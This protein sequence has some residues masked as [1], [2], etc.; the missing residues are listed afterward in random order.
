MRHDPWPF[1]ED[2][3]LERARRIALSYRSALLSIDPEHCRRL[4][5]RAVELG[6]SW[7]RPLVSEVTDLDERLTADQ[8]GEL[9]TI[10]PRTVRMWG[11]RGHIDVLGEGGKP[12]YRLGDVIDYLAKARQ[13]RRNDKAAGNA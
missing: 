8:I 13:A 7:V 3:L 11:Y 9:F 5:D 4:D 6:Q 1:P 10:N 12:L 2:T